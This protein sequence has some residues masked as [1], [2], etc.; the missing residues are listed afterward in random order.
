VLSLDPLPH[1]WD[2]TVE[3]IAHAQPAST[4]CRK[5][6]CGKAA[7]RGRGS[8]SAGVSSR[9]G[10]SATSLTADHDRAGPQIGVLD[11]PRTCAPSAT[12]VAAQDMPVVRLVPLYLLPSWAAIVATS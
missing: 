3:H 11:A 10:T 2:D 5:T 8:F 9:P 12:T 7:K 4:T 1:K 6:L